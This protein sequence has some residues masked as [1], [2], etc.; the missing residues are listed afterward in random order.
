MSKAKS[1]NERDVNPDLALLIRATLTLSTSLRANG[2]AQAPPD[3]RLREAI[4][5]AAKEEWLASSLTL[6]AMTAIAASGRPSIRPQLRL[7]HV[8]S[9]LADH[10]GRRIGVAA[11]QGRHDRGI[12]DAQAFNATD[13]Q[14]G[15]DHRHRVDAHLAG[16]DRMIDGIDALAQHLADIGVGLDAGGEYVGCLQRLQ[17][18]RVKQPFCHLETSHHGIDVGILA[19]EGPIDYPRSKRIG[20]L[21]PDAAAALWPQQADMAAKAGAPARLAALIAHHRHAEMQLDI[22]HVE[23]GAGFE[24]TAAFGDVRG[25]R[26]A[27]LP[28]VLRDPLENS[29]DAGK[30]QAGEIRRVRGE[31]EYKVRMILQVLSDAGQ[32]MRGRDAVLRQ[33]GAIA[34]AGK[35]Q[36]LRAL[37]R[38]GGKDHFT[39]GPGFPAL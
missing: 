4:H 5:R 18:R 20:A 32:M 22:V 29:R 7:D 15:I 21:Q 10:D 33:R 30:R 34:D 19:A 26:P 35:H 24:E 8:G 31:A 14:L 36:E 2:S 25:H 1:G 38:A 3:D 6:L 17:R 37:K 16:A 13:F 27:T 39:A 9:L 23:V 28:P 11:D 12:D